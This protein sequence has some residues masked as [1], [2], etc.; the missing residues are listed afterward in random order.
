[1]MKK[2]H[3]V[4]LFF[5]S[6]FAL[7]LIIKLFCPQKTPLTYNDIIFTFFFPFC[8]P[9]NFFFTVSLSLSISPVVS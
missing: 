8:L 3:V 7:K 2:I 5:F 9:P 6:R 1:M 4:Q